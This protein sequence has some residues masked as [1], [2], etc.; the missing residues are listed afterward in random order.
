MN[1]KELAL[2]GIIIGRI[3]KIILALE[4]HNLSAVCRKTGISYVVLQR[5]MQG[6]T[7]RP[8]LDTIARLEAYL[9]YRVN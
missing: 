2:K 3:D 7:A 9:G 8:S 1:T 5:F 4:D 6:K